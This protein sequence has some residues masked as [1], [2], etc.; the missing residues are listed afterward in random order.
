MTIL[1]SQL[2]GCDRSFP[3]MLLPPRMG[4]RPSLPAD[5]FTGTFLRALEPAPDGVG[6]D[7]GLQAS[8]ET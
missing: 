6:G 8:G 4:A 5:R 7:D 2:T 1:T 3:W